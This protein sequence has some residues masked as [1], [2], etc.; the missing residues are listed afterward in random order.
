LSGASS[1]R[2]FEISGDVGVNHNTNDEHLSGVSSTGF[3]GR[4]KV[5][6]EPRWSI[7]F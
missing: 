5:T 2:D 6:I 7:S 3:E 4:V 1:W